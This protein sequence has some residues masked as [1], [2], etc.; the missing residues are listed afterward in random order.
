MTRKTKFAEVDDSQIAAL[1]LFRER[2]GRSWKTD[3]WAAWMNGGDT[4]EPGGAALR[5]LRNSSGP[6]W[7]DTLRPNDLDAEA[8]RRGVTAPSMSSGAKSAGEG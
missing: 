8:T 6:S 4:R 7:L 3:L 2:Y 1:L 5:Q